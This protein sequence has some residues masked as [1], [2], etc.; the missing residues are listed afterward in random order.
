MSFRSRLTRFDRRSP[1]FVMTAVVVGI[2]LLLIAWIIA[3]QADDGVPSA[4]DVAVRMEQRLPRVS[5]VQGRIEL[6]NG[7]AVLEQELWIERP[8]RLRAEVEA[9]PPGVAPVGPNQKTTLVLSEE[10]AWFYNPTLGVATV[11]S[12]ANYTPAASV[13]VGGS[14]LESMPEAVLAALQ[15]AADIQLIGEDRVAGRQTL[16]MQI[17][18]AQPQAPFDA[19][20]I[21][22]GLD[23]EFFYPLWIETDR[24]FALR[25]QNVQFNQAIDPATFVFVPPA[26]IVVNRINE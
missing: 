2:A 20:R 22:V 14:I 4:D 1:A 17:L 3:T 8:R 11:T 5:T 6:V 23:R 16:R 13:D 25:F 21:T 26:G 18:M 7:A 12:R 19:Q 9:G 10:E 24:G 15:N